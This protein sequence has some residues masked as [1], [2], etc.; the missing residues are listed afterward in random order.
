MCTLHHQKR[1]HLSSLFSFSSNTEEPHILTRVLTSPPLVFW[2]PQ[3]SQKHCIY[4]D[5]ERESNEPSSRCFHITHWGLFVSINQVTHVV[6]MH[7]AFRVSRLQFCLGN[8]LFFYHL[9]WKGLEQKTASLVSYLV[10]FHL[11][12]LHTGG[13]SVWAVDSPV[14]FLLLF[15]YSFMRQTISLLEKNNFDWVSFIINC[16]F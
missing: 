1:I 14:I 16:S 6:C 9:S 3:S 11:C 10:D 12:R 13:K 15:R 4:H 7:H 2:W 8:K 5:V